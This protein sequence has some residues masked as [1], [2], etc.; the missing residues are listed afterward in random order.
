MSRTLRTAGAL[1]DAGLLSP[2]DV[3]A[4]APVQARYAIAVTPHLV[5]QMAKG[6]EGVARQFLP[7]TAE[8]SLQPEERADPIG[9]HAHSPVPGVVHRYP[10]RVLL[11]PVHVCPVY[12]RFCFRREM[13]GPQGLALDPAALDTAL[14]FIESQD[15]VSEVIVTGGDPLVLSPGRLGRL[16]ERIAA[17]PHV[18]VVRL[19][20]RVPVATPARVTADL[21]QALRVPGVATWVAVHTNHPDELAPPEVV[22]ALDTLVDA[23][24]PLV[25]QTVLLKSVNNDVATLTALLRRLVSLRVKPYYLHHGDLAPGTAHFR[26]SLSEGRALVA[27]LRGRLSGLCQPT[28]VLDIPGG[29]GKVPAGPSWVESAG[30]DHFTVRDWQGGT[31]VYPPRS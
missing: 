20:T 26:T 29:Y 24:I 25:S 12:C 4:I 30:P 23:G 15:G 1:S 19:H 18:A 9:D 3:A 11:K 8:L 21:A 5:E 27:E 6:S 7:T 13:V 17:I 28:Y 16:L 22:M 14:G 31:H 10:D 2:A